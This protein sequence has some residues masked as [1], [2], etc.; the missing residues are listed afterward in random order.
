MLKHTLIALAG[1]AAVVP[2]A[3]ADT[4]LPIL[5][6]PD[7]V[8]DYTPFEDHAFDQTFELCHRF[9]VACSVPGAGHA[10][11]LDLIALAQADA[12]KRWALH[13]E[14]WEEVA[15]LY[16]D[17]APYHIPAP[18]LPRIHGNYGWQQSAG[19]RIADVAE[20]LEEVQERLDHRPQALH[21][22]PRPHFNWQNLPGRFSFG[23][24]GPAI[25]NHYNLPRHPGNTIIV[26]PFR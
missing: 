2:A 21:V 11:V 1:L 12:A 19:D 23:H 7:L 18:R 25:I 9:G 3:S 6:R 14:E 15:E 26:N 4:L 17:Y 22:I 16:D 20:L 8:E 10:D 24:S 5:P 13:A